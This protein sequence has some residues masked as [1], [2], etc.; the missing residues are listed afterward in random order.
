MMSIARL[1]P[2]SQFYNE[3]GDNLAHEKDMIK[4]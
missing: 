1:V 2:Q 4:C 3:P